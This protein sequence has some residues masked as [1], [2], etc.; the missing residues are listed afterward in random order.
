MEIKNETGFALYRRRDFE[1]CPE[2]S[3]ERI[4]IETIETTLVGGHRKVGASFVNSLGGL[5]EMKSGLGDTCEEAV[6][7]LLS[8]VTN[9]TWKELRNRVDSNLDLG[10]S[11]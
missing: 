11:D 7:D 5:A 10:I 8:K 1:L 6:E 4:I 3:T 2:G 9:L